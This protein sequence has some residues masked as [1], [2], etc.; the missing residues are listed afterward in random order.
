MYLP[1]WFHRRYVLGRYHKLY[2]FWHSESFLSLHC[3]HRSYTHRRIILRVIALQTWTNVPVT[4]SMTVMVYASTYLERMIAAALRA[5]DFRTTLNV[6]TSTNVRRTWPAVSRFAPIR[7]ARTSA[8]VETA[9]C[10]RVIPLV[11]TLMNVQQLQRITAVTRRSKSV[12]T[13]LVLL[14]VIV[15]TDIPGMERLH[16]KVRS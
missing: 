8:L 6:W 2:I 13:H 14:S 3:S 16:V 1:C 5:I 11:K 15:Q 12:K 4:L 10:W 7:Q 9:T